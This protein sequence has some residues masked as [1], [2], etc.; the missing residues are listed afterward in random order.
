VEALASSL[1][2]ANHFVLIRGADHF[3]AGKLDRLSAALSSW[4]L[5]R[6]PDLASLG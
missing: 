4:L 6:H 2:G 1:P 5:S 3:F